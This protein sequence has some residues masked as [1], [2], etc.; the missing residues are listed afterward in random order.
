MCELYEKVSFQN[1]L[2]LERALKRRAKLEKTIAEMDER[3]A[4]APWKEEE[5]EV[6]SAAVSG[7]EE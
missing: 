6:S 3:A 7:P 1:K 2:V 4:N 5:D